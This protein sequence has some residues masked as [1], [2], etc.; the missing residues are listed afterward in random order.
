MKAERGI[1][2]P[3]NVIEKVTSMVDQVKDLQKKS[4]RSITTSVD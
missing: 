3:K 2:K 4:T 1:N